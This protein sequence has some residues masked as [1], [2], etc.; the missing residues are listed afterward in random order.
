L[1]AEI[2]NTLNMPAEQ[3]FVAWCLFGCWRQG[4]SFYDWYNFGV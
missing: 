3:I 2:Y 1:F 4:G